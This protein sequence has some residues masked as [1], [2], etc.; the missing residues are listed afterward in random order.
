MSRSSADP[1]MNP[2]PRRPSEV[3]RNPRSKSPHAMLELMVMRRGAGCDG[4][5]GLVG[6]GGLASRALGAE[7]ACR[8]WGRGRCRA[9]RWHPPASHPDQKPLAP[10]RWQRV[11]GACPPASLHA[12]RDGPPGDQR[13]QGSSRCWRGRE[14]RPALSDGRGAPAM[15]WLARGRLPV[16]RPLPMTSSGRQRRCRAGPGLWAVSLGG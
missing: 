1:K 15:R 7:S 12:R 10:A 16:L 2:P 3:A 8:L 5:R 4:S 14:Y 6:V 13:W 11:R 9:V